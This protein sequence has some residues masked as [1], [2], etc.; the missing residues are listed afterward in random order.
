MPCP[1]KGGDV[2]PRLVG[3]FGET[4]VL[5]TTSFIKAVH[6]QR[7]VET[8]TGRIKWETSLTVPNTPVDELLAHNWSVVRRSYDSVFGTAPVMNA[9]E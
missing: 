1:G 3:A 9:A 7:A 2:L 8:T 5:D 6:R 4:T